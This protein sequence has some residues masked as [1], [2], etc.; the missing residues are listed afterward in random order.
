MNESIINFMQKQTCAT[1]SCVSE[2]GKSYCFN[3]F[4]AFNN[5]KAV[6][7]Y[8][9][10]PTA[11][12]SVLMKKNPAVSGTILPD[13][14][15]ILLVQGIQ[16]EGQVLETKDALA[17]KAAGYYYKKHPVGLAMPGEIWAIQI[18][19]IKMTDSSKGFGGKIIWER[20]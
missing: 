11:Q 14:L 7:Y 6:L 3:C 5:E 12:H 4:Y 17:E 13:K 18:N 1:I 2:D 16:F 8:K 20:V 9:T 10:S 15:K 19:H